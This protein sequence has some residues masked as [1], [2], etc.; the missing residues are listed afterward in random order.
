MGTWQ[1]LSAPLCPGQGLGPGVG[2]GASGSPWAPVYR[3]REKPSP[4]STGPC[5]ANY[6]SRASV[7]PAL[8]EGMKPLSGESCRVIIL[9]FPSCSVV[10]K[11]PRPHCTPRLPQHLPV[12][13]RGKS[14]PVGRGA[15]SSQC[16]VHAVDEGPFA[17]ASGLC[18]ALARGRPACTCPPRPH[19]GAAG[20]RRV[21]SGPVW[22]R[23]SSGKGFW[24][25]L[26]LPSEVQVSSP[27]VIQQTFRWGRP[28]GSTLSLLVTGSWGSLCPTRWLQG[29][30][31]V[32]WGCVRLGFNLASRGGEGRVC[33]SKF[34]LQMR[35]L[36]EASQGLG[37]HKGSRTW[38]SPVQPQMD[39]QEDTGSQVTGL[40]RRP[41]GR[42]GRLRTGGTACFQG[43]GD[44]GPGPSCLAGLHQL[45]SQWQ[46]QPVTQRQGSALCSGQASRPRGHAC[47]GTA[48]CLATTEDPAQG[49]PLPKGAGSALGTG[50]SGPVRLEAEARPGPAGPALHPPPPEPQL[51][52]LGTTFRWF[53]LCTGRPPRGALREPCCHPGP[54]EP[55]VCPPV[56]PAPPRR[57]PVSWVTLHVPT[58]SSAPVA[59]P[60]LV[61]TPHT[62]R[63]WLGQGRPPGGVGTGLHWRGQSRGQSP[64]PGPPPGSPWG[65]CP[66]RLSHGPSRPQGDPP[67]PPLL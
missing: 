55:S 13:S 61:L 34:C 8:L 18:R 63:R 43:Q 59:A 40:G 29:R 3:L 23:Q 65:S 46:P 22:Q 31:G 44:R 2:A 19:E 38:P 24:E 36:S 52:P 50:S 12:A 30:K 35:H 64:T 58:V 14:R 5:P 27:L 11:V 66:R 15:L 60:A 56:S 41:S 32:G 17:P 1:V 67:W 42:L 54:G 20:L 57:P 4:L 16:Q 9:R 45:S 21:L 51:R 6:P 62:R 49:W 53:Q 39:T 47:P 10:P 25:K 37:P 28:W 33:P 26:L 7:S 48:A